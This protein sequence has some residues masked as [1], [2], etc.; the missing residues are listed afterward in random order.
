MLDGGRLPPALR[1]RGGVHLRGPRRGR[2]G[3]GRGGAGLHMAAVAIV[4]GRRRG[5]DRGLP[6]QA[7]RHP[8]RGVRG[9]R[10]GRRRHPDGA[11]RGISR[12][13][14]PQLADG[15]RPER[16]PTL[17]SQLG[18]DASRVEAQREARKRY[19]VRK[20]KLVA[21]ADVAVP[22]PH[23]PPPLQRRQA[24]HLRRAAGGAGRLADGGERRHLRAP[25][26]QP[27]SAGLRRQPLRRRHLRGR[28]RAALRSPRAPPAARS[29]AHPRLGD[30]G[31]GADDAGRT[32]RAG[33][34]R[35]PEAHLVRGRTPGD[36]R[37]AGA[38]ARA[39]RSASRR[40]SPSSAGAQGAGR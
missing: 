1:V 7:P 19:I 22:A 26:V 23:H 17:L 13:A 37:R 5:A 16:S 18:L 4:G 24:R 38:R 10:A 35:G 15:R 40:R 6:P 21:A 30:E 25:A 34:C 9:L 14:R 3:G 33:L 27:G 36:S 20:S 8:G 28:S 29:G 39:P 11:A 31:A 12:R 32:R 2:A